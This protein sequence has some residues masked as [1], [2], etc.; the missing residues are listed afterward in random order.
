VRI[1]TGCSVQASDHTKSRAGSNQMDP[2]HYIHL[3][4]AGVDIRGSHIGLFIQRNLS[5]GGVTVLAVSLLDSRLESFIKEPLSR[6]KEVVKH[7]AGRKLV[8]SPRSTHLV[9]LS[10]ALRWWNHVLLCFNQQLVK[11]VRFSL[12][13]IFRG[14]FVMLTP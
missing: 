11:H 2:F 8:I 12:D 6:I 14:T 1:V 9:F 13:G 3:S 7:R 5:T 10:S 4:G